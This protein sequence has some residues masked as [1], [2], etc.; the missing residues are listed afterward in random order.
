MNRLEQRVSVGWASGHKSRHGHLL[1][2]RSG[3]SQWFDY[4]GAS[5][6][7]SRLRHIRKQLAEK[8]D[9]ISGLQYQIKEQGERL[10]K[11]EQF[12]RDV[13]E[14]TD[15]PEYGD[16]EKWLAS[17]KGVS[18]YQGKNVAFIAGSGVIASSESLDELMEFL[19]KNGKPEGI[20]IGFVPTSGAFV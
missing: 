9:V 15:L 2:G 3:G 11:L 10:S 5:L 12:V 14:P 6:E 13:F 17:G 8:N 18:E 7:K 4:M 20:I 1:L 19:R 16:F